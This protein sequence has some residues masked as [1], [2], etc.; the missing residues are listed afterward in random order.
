[1]YGVSPPCARMFAG[2]V[3]TSASEFTTEQLTRDVALSKALGI[4]LHLMACINQIPDHTKTTA[5]QLCDD[6]NL[7][8]LV[9]DKSQ[10]RP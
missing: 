8:L 7:E 10:L 1:M 6:A 2:E 5:R 3:K 9:L 4:D